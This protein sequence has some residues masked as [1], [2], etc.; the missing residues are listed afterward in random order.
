[1]TPQSQL[2]AVEVTVDEIVERAT[3]GF[4]SDLQDIMG[5]GKTDY[6]EN[7]AIALFEASYGANLRAWSDET[8]QYFLRRADAALS[9][10]SDGLREAVIQAVGLGLRDWVVKHNGG[11]ITK[12][13]RREMGECIADRPEIIALLPAGVEGEAECLRAH[14]AH[15]ESRLAAVDVLVGDGFWNSVHEAFD[16]AGA[17]RKSDDGGIVYGIIDRINRLAALNVPDRARGRLE[18]LEE[19]AIIERC[20]VAARNALCDM[21]WPPTDGDRQIDEVLAAIRALSVRGE[22]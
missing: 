8:R 17:P 6:R 21:E 4:R 13:M 16:R 20:A 22:G 12:G 15:L 5:K 18:G 2:E 10:A 3:S 14:V 19:A 7:L 11:V 1:M 9:P